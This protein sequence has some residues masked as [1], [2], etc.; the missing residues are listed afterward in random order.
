MGNCNMKLRGFPDLTTNNMAVTRRACRCPGHV[1]ISARRESR[2]IDK[3]FC[4][5]YSTVPNNA[6][7]E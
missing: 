1:T 2:S 5:A 6:S 3:A 7:K 4:Y